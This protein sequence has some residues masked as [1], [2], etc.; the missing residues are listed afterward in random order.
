[1]FDKYPSKIETLIE[2]EAVYKKHAPLIGDTVVEQYNNKIYIINA[3]LS[4]KDCLVFDLNDN[5][6]DS[7]A[8][9]TSNEYYNGKRFCE[10]MEFS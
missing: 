5:L 4:I 8:T 3:N 1:M 6:I 10:W 2:S 9:V 7:Y